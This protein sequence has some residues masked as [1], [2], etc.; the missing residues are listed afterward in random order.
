MV[1]QKQGMKQI[2]FFIVVSVLLIAIGGVFAIKSAL[3]G[4]PG[5]AGNVRKQAVGVVVGF[6]AMVWLARQEYETLLMRVAR[7]LCNRRSPHVSGPGREQ[8]S[9][10]PIVEA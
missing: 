8:S 6:A 2:D 4:D 3:H 10:R 1:A 9:R 5:S 7:C